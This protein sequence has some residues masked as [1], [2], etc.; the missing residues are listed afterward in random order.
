MGVGVVAGIGV[1]GVGGAAAAF[2]PAGI[3]A[4]AAFGPAAILAPA[5]FNFA[6]NSWQNTTEIQGIA[7]MYGINS[8]RITSS[9]VGMSH[10]IDSLQQRIDKLEQEIET[11]TKM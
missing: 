7:T 11:W 9:S 10:A 5:I 2:S 1:G 6:K 4:V 3:G 8:P